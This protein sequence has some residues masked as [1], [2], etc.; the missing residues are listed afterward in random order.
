V[1]EIEITVTAKLLIKPDNQQSELLLD[2][3][4]AFSKAC[5]YISGVV[6]DTH[7]LNQATLQ[8]QVYDTLRTDYG[9]PSQL[10]CN[11]V[12]HVIGNYRT[13][14]ANQ[15]EWIKP[16]YKHTAFPLSWNRDYLLRGD[17]F[18]VGTLQGRIKLDYDNGGMEK[19]FDGSWTFGLAKVVNKHG[20][21]Y[22]HISMSK[23]FEQVQDF[24]VCNVVGVDLGINFTATAY[25]SNGETTFYSGKH[26][27][28][29][30]AHYKN[31]RK[32]LQRRQTPSA[33]RRLKAIGSR[34]NRWVQDINHCVSKTLVDNNP[35]GTAFVLEDLTGIRAATERVRLKDR[36][37]SVSWAFYDLRQKL[38][39]KAK[40]SDNKVII[41][42]PKH[43][44]QTCP[45]CGHTERA[46]RDKKRHIFKCRNCAYTSNDDRIGAMNLHR[47]GIEYL[48]ACLPDRRAV[49]GE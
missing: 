44:S 9:M 47:K 25:D 28:H 4:R 22:L 48:S 26:I 15:D 21:W 43:T 19:Y 12:R 8:K 38:E 36:Y 18:S 1:I 6:F 16:D 39:Y 5:N 17:Y 33:R 13:I 29:K 40:M 10:A 20:K 32:E 31:I 34:E 24:D 46:N 14:L 23:E 35:K 11:A 41:V 37:V 30:R 27:K 42:D 3:G 7:N 2:T 45:K 49:T